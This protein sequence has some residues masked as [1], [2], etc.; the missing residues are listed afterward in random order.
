MRADEVGRQV[1]R[2]AW[3]VLPVGDTPRSSKKETN[4]LS[5]SCS[6]LLEQTHEFED[7]WTSIF[8]TI[9]KRL[10]ENSDLQNALN[11]IADRE[12]QE[13]YWTVIDFMFCEI[14][15]KYKPD[16]KKF[17]EG[18]GKPLRDIIKREEWQRANFAMHMTLT[19]AYDLFCQK[20]VRSWKDIRLDIL[21]IAA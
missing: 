5:Q 12:I 18:S 9:E 20:R 11:F 19:R 1:F 7:G 13:E 17:Y 2:L 3:G 14:F 4:V 16:C 21:E 6:L 8:P 15:T 10:N